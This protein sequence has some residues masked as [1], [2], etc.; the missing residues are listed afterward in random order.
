MLNDYHVSFAFSSKLPSLG[1]GTLTRYGILAHSG[2]ICLEIVEQVGGETKMLTSV[3]ASHLH[4]YVFKAMK[5]TRRA[6][7]SSTRGAGWTGES[8]Q[9]SDS[10][11]EQG[12][13]P[14][15][16]PKDLHPHVIVNAQ[17]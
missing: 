12:Q 9:E 7:K 2:H 10:E 6:A 13:Q 3:F 4:A 14:R 11:D 1:P 17:P 8:Y 5:R 15:E 16:R